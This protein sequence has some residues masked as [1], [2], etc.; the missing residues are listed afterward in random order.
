MIPSVFG[1]ATLDPGSPKL[2]WFSRLKNS[3]RNIR[4]SLSVSGNDFC[5]EAS[6]LNDPIPRRK[7]RGELPNVFTVLNATIPGSK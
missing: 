5:R 7:L 4:L 2:A 1:E 3:P 6:I